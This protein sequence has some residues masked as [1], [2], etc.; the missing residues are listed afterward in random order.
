MEED[1][2]SQREEKASILQKDGLNPYP[3]TVKR[4]HTAQEV[5]QIIEE[6]PSGKTNDTVEV[7]VVG[8]IMAQRSMGRA[9]FFDILDGTSRIQILFRKNSIGDDQY[10]KLRLLDLGDFISVTGTPMQT[11]TGEATIEAIAWNILA[12]T[13][14]PPPEKFHGLKNIELRQRQRYLDLLSNDEVRTRFLL[15]SAITSAIRAYLQAEDYLEVETPIL[16]EEAGGAAARPFVSYSNALDEERYLRISLEL[17]LKRLIIGGYEKVFEIGKIFRNEGF[18]N[19]HHPE[20][21]ML[22][23]Y[24][25]YTSYLDVAVL[26]EKMISTVAKDV[27][28]KTTIQIN[29][30]NVNLEPPWERITFHEALLKFG[31]FDLL[32]YPDFDTLLKA[33]QERNVPIPENSN[34]GKLLDVAMS[35]FVEPKL[36]KPTFVLDY[37]VEL[38]P[39]AK[40]I[41]NNPNLVER[42]EAFLGGMELANAYSELNDPVDQ[43]LRFEEQKKLK[44]SGD[45]EAELMDEDFL[46]ALEHGMPPTGGLGIGID[47]LVLLLTEEQ[48]IREVILFPQHRKILNKQTE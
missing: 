46:L 27:L 21:T 23:A 32:S 42:F 2:K 13:L 48:N 41:P 9:S 1:L 18:S 38:S 37:P 43:R 8:R 16:Q 24:A 11:R 39:L 26:V 28:G 15:R 40:R 22:E 29:G 36:I 10:Q 44:E 34:Y 6:F 14:L 3:A 5:V 12:K 19:K 20:F 35:A 30:I 17:F 45:E 25:A 47:R 7:H 31:N 33:L 4:T